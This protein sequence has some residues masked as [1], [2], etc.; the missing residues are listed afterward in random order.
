MNYFLGIDLGGTNIAAAVLDEQYHIV[1]QDNRKTGCPRTAEEIMDDMVGAALGAL[2]KA[3]L[4]LM[5]IPYIGV[6]CPG[7]VNHATRVI[8]YSN[9]LNFHQVAMGDY[10]E[11]K[12]LKPV[13]IENDANAAAWGEFL[14]GAAKGSE[15]FVA[16]TLG[17]GVGSGIILDKKIY[18]GS[19]DA[20]GEL[21]HTVLCLGGRDCT[22][23]RKGCFETY[24]SATGLIVTTKEYMQKYKNSKMWELTEGDLSEVDGR[25][26]FDALRLGDE[27]GIL[28]VQDY[29]AALAAGITNAINIFQPDILSVAGGISK[30]GETL[31]GPVREI[32]SQEDYARNSKKRTQIVTAALGNDAGVVGAA[33]LGVSA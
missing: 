3:G 19:N 5:D 15:N 12:F 26:A 20:G 31:L 30:E 10:L 21:G 2:K 23:G 27:A 32:V 13:L 14:A 7:T 16:I 29:T 25:T 1:A 9:N 4:T 18:R 22:C 24:A 11:K 33:L 17:T 6:G 8:E 28:A